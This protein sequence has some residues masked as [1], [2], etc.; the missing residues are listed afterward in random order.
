MKQKMADRDSFWT[1]WLQD[2]YGKE[3]PPNAVSRLIDWAWQDKLKD[4]LTKES[5]LLCATA[6]AWVL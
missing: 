4:Y 6:L 5:R 1:I 2:K 3:V